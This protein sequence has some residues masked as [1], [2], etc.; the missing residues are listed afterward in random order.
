MLRVTEQD[1]KSIFTDIDILLSRLIETKALKIKLDKG[2]ILFREREKIDKIYIVIS[3]KVSIFK[4][5]EKGQRRVIYILDSGSFINEDSIDNS[6]ASINCKAFEDS[7]IMYFFRS[8]L[9]HMMEENFKLTKIIMS[10]MSKKMRR[11]YRQIKNT[12][13]IKMDKKVAAKLWKLAKDYGI[14]MEDGTLIDINISMTYLADMLGSTRETISRNMNLLE[15][16]GVIKIHNKKI[17]VVD[18]KKLSVYF[19]GI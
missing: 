6:S 18:P 5:S 7:Y 9:I 17:L 8:D 15:K 4:N 11:L 19:R 12:V 13:P 14:K 2:K 10:S 1:I 16:I 3:G